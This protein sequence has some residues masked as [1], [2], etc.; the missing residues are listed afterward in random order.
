MRYWWW[1]TRNHFPEAL[2]HAIANRL[3]RRIAYWAA[4]RVMAH[5][6][7]GPYSNQ[8]VPELTVMDAL[9]RWTESRPR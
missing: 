3:P 9:K 5:A 2:A 4:I 8:V 1:R 7:V 6:T